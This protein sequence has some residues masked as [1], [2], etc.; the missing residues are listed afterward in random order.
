MRGQGLCGRS[1]D[2]LYKAGGGGGCG[3]TVAIETSVGAAFCLLFIPEKEAVTHTTHAR[4]SGILHLL[5]FDKNTQ[6]KERGAPAETP[7]SSALDLLSMH[8]SR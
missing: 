2:L 8:I 1:Q 4:H 7:H 6:A 3:S 5:H